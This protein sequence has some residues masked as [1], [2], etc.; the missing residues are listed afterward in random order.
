MVRYAI[1]GVVVCM[2]I[3]ET[4]LSMTELWFGGWILRVRE[5]RIRGWMR[6]EDIRG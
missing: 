4:V 1:L 6:S 2:S 3:A 5:G